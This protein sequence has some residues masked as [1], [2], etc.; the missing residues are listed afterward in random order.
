MAKS[1]QQ[2]NPRV[3]QIFEDLEGYLAFCQDYGYKFDEA[4]LYDMRVFAYRQ[5]TKLLGNKWPKDQWQEDM[6]P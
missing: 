4:Q 5:Y 2:S 6:R 1:Q 3:Y